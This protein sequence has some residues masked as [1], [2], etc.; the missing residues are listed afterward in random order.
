MNFFVSCLLFLLFIWVLAQVSNSIKGG[1]TTKSCQLPPGPRR[2]PIFGNLLDL[3]N[4]PHKS[5]AELAKTHGPIMSL[6]LGNL[7]TVVVS[8][9][10]MAK[11]V[12]QKNDLILSNRIT[13]D[14]IRALQ[15]HE[16]GLPWIPVSPLWRNLRKV[17]NLHIFASQ[18]LDANQSLRRKKIEQLLSSVQ[19]SYR[20]GEAVDI[21]QEAFKTT[22]NLLS[23]TVFSI[24]L[25][26]SHSQRAQQFKKTVRSVLEEAGKPNLA[27]YFPLL[28]KIDPQGVRRRMAIHFEMLLELFGKMYDKRV[29]LRRGQGFA[30]TSDVLDTLI[31]II[32]DKTEELNRR[33]TLHLFLV[34]FVAGTDTT[35][36]TLEWAMA[37]LLHNPNVLLKARVELE[38]AIGKGRQVEESDI[39][40]LPYLE[41]IIK[42]TFRM[43]PPVPLLLPRRAGADAEICGFTVPE[44]AQV[45]VNAWAIGRDPSIWEK[46]NCFM[47]ERFLGSEMDVKGRN[48]ELIPF[49]GGR[50]ICPGLPLALRMLHLMLGSL[51]NCFEW[52]LEDGV[53]PENMN[54][55][56]KF[57]LTLQK[58]IPLRAIPIPA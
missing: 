27:D 22:V 4:E 14:A 38:E 15:H 6:K 42:E 13:I 8:S 57:G 19:D 25:A 16:I 37:E 23:N 50:R 12:L 7:I 53:T 26:D 43:H 34:L 17:C 52:K 5:L 51:I 36:S 56:E 10:A 31:D 9:A 29:Q 41:A 30:T 1:S 39:V 40:R 58:A 32:E 48:F 54:M 21:G 2:I 28:R 35:A 49:G 46:P 44:G 18:K 20:L 24:D 55:E 47:P 33:Q 11:E 3:G 45:L